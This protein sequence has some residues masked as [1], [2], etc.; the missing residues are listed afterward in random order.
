MSAR[1]KICVPVFGESVTSFVATLIEVQQQ[2]PF[3]ELRVDSIRDVTPDDLV[4]IRKAC[5][6]R[7]ILTCRLSEDGGLYH[8][9]P[10]SRDEL[11]RQAFA[12]GFDLI[13]IEI[14]HIAKL[15]FDIT[16]LRKQL[17]LSTHNFECTPEE[18]ELKNLLEHMMSF[19][20][21][22]CKLALQ[23]RKESDCS[24]L[25][26]LLCNYQEHQSLI[27][28]GMG[29]R[30]RMTRILCPLLGSLASF[31]EPVGANTPRA[32]GQLSAKKMRE[33]FDAIDGT[34]MS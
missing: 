3:V 13:D 26:K 10:S 2:Y 31:A 21:A 14:D 5:H 18:N 30:G 32:L 19:Q 16:P 4:E 34:S 1:N 17:L 8:D 11:F 24:R 9:A 29:P 22:V 25:F 12:L 6:V 28:V 20:P 7:C 27:V 23:I 33:I 15:N